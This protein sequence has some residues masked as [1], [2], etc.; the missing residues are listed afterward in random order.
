MLLDKSWDF[1]D[2]DPLNNG[3]DSR[4]GASKFQ[5]KAIKVLKNQIDVRQNNGSN[6]ITGL[7]EALE[8]IKNL[9]A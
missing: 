9:K 5:E 3:W 6:S 8:I 4:R 1:L 7:V 2:K